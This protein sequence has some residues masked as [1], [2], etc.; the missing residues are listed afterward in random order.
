MSTL[1]P[2]LLADLRFGW[3]FA[4]ACNH[5]DL[6]ALGSNKDP[7]LEINRHGTIVLGE[8]TVF[9]LDLR[10]AACKLGTNDSFIIPGETLPPTC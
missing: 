8:N 5:P 2:Q 7:A 3:L 1:E 6:L 9:P 4:P 10:R